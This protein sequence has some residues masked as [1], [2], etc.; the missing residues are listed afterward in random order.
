[1][2]GRV[3]PGADLCLLLDHDV[4]DEQG[5]AEG[6][7]GRRVRRLR[8]DPDQDGAEAL[9]ERGREVEARVGRRAPS[10]MHQEGQ[11]AHRRTSAPFGLRSKLD[12]GHLDGG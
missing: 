8:R 1:L 9:G 12:F 3:E 11:V 6:V 4:A 2:L 5:A 7:R 10:R